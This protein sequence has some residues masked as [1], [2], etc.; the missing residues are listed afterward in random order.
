MYICRNCGQEINDEFARDFGNCP[1]LTGCGSSNIRQANQ[2]DGLK[3]H[4][5]AEAIQDLSERLEHLEEC[6]QR[7]QEH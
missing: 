5:L 4:E 2:F 3:S 1:S 7:L 6:V